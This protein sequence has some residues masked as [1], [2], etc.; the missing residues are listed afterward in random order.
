[1]PYFV[2][3]FYRNTRHKINLKN[4]QNLLMKYIFFFLFISCFATAQNFDANY[5]QAKEDYENDFL[6]SPFFDKAIESCPDINQ[7][8]ELLNYK[9]K[10]LLLNNEYLLATQYA[11]LALS[12][13][14][15]KEDKFEILDLL[16]NIYGFQDDS[17]QSRKYH[18]EILKLAKELNSKDKIEHATFNILLEDYYAAEDKKTALKQLL[19]FYNS[20]P[21]ERE[22]AVKVNYMTIIVDLSRGALLQEEYIELKKDSDAIIERKELKNSTLGELYNSYSILESYFNNYDHALKYCDSS[23][24]ISKKH[25]TK[26]DVL[27]DLYTYKTIYQELG[28]TDEALKYTDSILLIEQDVKINQIETG[29]KLI[30]ENILFNKIQKQTSKKN[31]VLNILLLILAA[32]VLVVIFFLI[33]S[34][35]KRL[36][37]QSGLDFHKDKYN[38]LWVNY[39]LSTRQLEK[40]KEELINQAKTTNA[41]GELN[42]LLKDLSIHLNTSKDD[43]HKHINMLKDNFVNALQEKAPYLNNQEQLICFFINLNFSHKKIGELLNK[44]EKSIESYKY[45]INSKVKENHN[46][47][48]NDLLDSL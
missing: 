12:L 16:A 41:N 24:A 21:K 22:I 38:N 4:T 2:F 7:Y 37:L 18:K 45:R 34:K 32:I 3:R 40:L 8:P 9:A 14:K 30:D 10:F 36:K 20:L 33:F 27:N 11:K 47:T 43:E 39:Q 19:E 6:E 46:I 26:Y 25:L 42:S 23:Y 29:L 13:A 17:K 48:V 1:M 5:K 35:R 15:R 31:S 28:N 44:S